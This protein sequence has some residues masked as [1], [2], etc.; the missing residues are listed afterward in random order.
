MDI[1]VGDKITYMYEEDCVQKVICQMVTDTTDITI[2]K[3]KEENKE[4]EIIKNERIGSNSWYIVYEK[5]ELLTEEERKF[6]KKII[7]SYNR[8]FKTKIR[9][10]Y[11]YSEKKLILINEIKEYEIE[12]ENSFRKLD[13]G[14]YY[15][16]SELG[17]EEN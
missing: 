7:E 12:V 14:A 4:I 17:L 6:L 1:Q 5:K 13:I 3:N 11:Y 16:L 15:A 8:M 10:I 9:K 2:L